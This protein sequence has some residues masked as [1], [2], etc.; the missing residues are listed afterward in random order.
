MTPV[1]RYAGLDVAAL[2]DAQAKARG[3]HPFLAWAPFDEPS[4]TWSYAA[5]AARAASLAGA[6]SAKGVRPGDRVMVALENCPEFLVAWFA[7]ARLGAILV[8]GNPALAPAE[9][10]WAASHCGAALRLSREDCASLEG[11]APTPRKPDPDTDVA[12]LYTSGTTA[13]P[14]G[15]LWTHGNALWAAQ[16]GAMQLGLRAEDRLQVCLPLCHVVGFSWSIL[17]ALWAGA[18]VVLQPRFSAS[19]YWDAALAHRAT[20][21]SHVQFTAGVLSRQ[22][23][24]EGHSF[25]LWGNSVWSRA[26]E[27][28]LGVRIAGWWGM[29]ELIAAGIV[30]DPSVPQRDGSIGR[31]SIGYAVRLVRDDGSLAPDDEPGHLQVLGVPGT[32]LFKR[33]YGDPQATV[34]AFTPDG[35]FRTGDRVVRHE[36][37]SIAFSERA[38]DVIKVG[39]ENVS[40]AEVER[41]M[42]EVPGVREAAVVGRSDPA[43]GE[44]VVAFVAGAGDDLAPRVAAHCAQVLAKFKVPREVVVVDALPRGNLGKIAK[45]E[46]KA[47]AAG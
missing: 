1:P 46:L 4:Q 9:L 15:V 14:K 29:T 22:P 41:A 17:P 45:N 10:D 7:C 3:E 16:L 43:F 26:L 6:L 13:R 23:V 12:I 31:A 37:G 42:L 32:S 40:P 8:A 33:Y 20:V 39:G 24:P 11:P 34:D 28:R 47:R 44:V 19:R 27:S 25:R 2:L 38:K 36:D 5:F 30:G 18:T 21:A 35:W